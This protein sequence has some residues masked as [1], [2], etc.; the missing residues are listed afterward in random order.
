MIKNLCRRA[1]LG[2]IPAL[3]LV[4]LPVAPARA[5]DTQSSTR[6]SSPVY[7]ST[8]IEVSPT[9]V[10]LPS[11]LSTGLTVFVLMGLFPSVRRRFRPPVPL[12]RP[13]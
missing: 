11:P 10:P 13:R 12:R 5:A 3:L 9:Q 4:T 6:S 8:G 2:A 1:C 7:N